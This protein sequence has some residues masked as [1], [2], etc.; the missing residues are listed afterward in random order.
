[1][2]YEMFKEVVIEKFKDYLPEAYRSMDMQVN[3]VEKINHTLDGIT[4]TSSAEGWKV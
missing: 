3:P 4:L 2:T 1:M